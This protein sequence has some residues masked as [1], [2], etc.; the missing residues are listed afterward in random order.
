M[1]SAILIS[2]QCGTGEAQRQHQILRTSCASDSIPTWHKKNIGTGWRN[3]GQI[4]N[5]PKQTA[6]HFGR[7]RGVVFCIARP[8]KH[9]VTLS[10]IFLQTFVS[11]ETSYDLMM[12]S[13]CF[14]SNA[15]RAGPPFFGPIIGLP[16]LTMLTL[17]D[18]YK[19]NQSITKHHLSGNRIG[20][21]GASAL[22]GALKD[23]L[24]VRFQKSARNTCVRT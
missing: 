5:V 6:L 18:H 8:W 2:D 4:C 13:C 16:L 3:N 11:L 24:V 14:F 23:A 10:G 7:C 22:A 19:S 1:L 17:C 12:R 15:L 9:L 21:D 20:D